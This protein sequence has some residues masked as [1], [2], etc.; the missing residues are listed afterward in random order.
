MF[1]R[2]AAKSPAP[3]LGLLAALLPACAATARTAAP[4]AARTTRVTLAARSGAAAPSAKAVRATRTH[5]V[6]KPVVIKP[7][8]SPLKGKILNPFGVQ[9]R[10]TMHSEKAPKNH[11]GVLDQDLNVTND[12]YDDVEPQITRDSTDLTVNVVFAANAAKD[13]YPP[14]AVDPT[15]NPNNLPPLGQQEPAFLAGVNDFHLY[16]R[17]GSNLQS[18]LIQIGL[19][20][21][22][23]DWGEQFEP[24]SGAGTL[25]AFSAFVAPNNDAYKPDIVKPDGTTG[26]PD[27]YGMPVR[28]ICTSTDGIPNAL[29]DNPG[30]I[31]QVL[32]PGTLKNPITY[33]DTSVDPPV[34]KYVP[35][36]VPDASPA[37]WPVNNRYILFVSLRGYDPKDPTTHY[38]SLWLWDTSKTPTDV[39]YVVKVLSVPGMSILHPK[40]SSDANGTYLLFTEADIKFDSDPTKND[41]VPDPVFGID[42]DESVLATSFTSRCYLSTFSV[43]DPPTGHAA[44][45]RLTGLTQITHYV[46][47]NNNAPRDM[48]PFMNDQ[49]Q[50][51]FSTDRVDADGDGLADGVQTDPT[52][53][54][55]DIYYF[56][57]PYDPNCSDETVPDS[58]AHRQTLGDLMVHTIPGD[59]TSPL[60]HFDDSNELHGNAA[61]TSFTQTILSVFTPDLYYQAD[62]A[63]PAQP[64]V[65]NHGWDIWETDRAGGGNVGAGP[66]ISYQGNILVGLPKVTPNQNLTEKELRN[67]SLTHRKGFPSNYVNISVNLNQNYYQFDKDTKAP[68]TEVYALVKD[69]DNRIYQERQST[70][71]PGISVPVYDEI[72]AFPVKFCKPDFEN[73]TKMWADVTD[74]PQIGALIKLKA[75]DQ[76]PH[77]TLPVAYTGKWYT[78]MEVS[79]FLIDIVVKEPAQPPAKTQTYLADNVGGF[80]TA[81]FVPSSRILVV[82]D[83]MAGQKAVDATT[84]VF[85]ASGAA[86]ESYVLN[87]PIGATAASGNPIF[88]TWNGNNQFTAVLGPRLEWQDAGTITVDPVSGR[89]VA[90]GQSYAMD[91]FTGQLLAG[92][93]AIFNAGDPM[94]VSSFDTFFGGPF[95]NMALGPH[96]YDL[97]RVQCREPI[98]VDDVKDGTG[99][100]AVYGV[101]RNYL[102]YTHTQPGY[103][104]ATALRTQRVADRCVLWFAPHAGDLNGNAGRNATEVG[105]IANVSTQAELVNYMD[106]GGRLLMSGSNVAAVLSNGDVT[107]TNALLARMK[108]AFQSD[109]DYDETHAPWQFHRTEAHQAR[110]GGL[111]GLNP[112]P[113]AMWEDH[114][115][116]NVA[117]LL[118]DEPLDLQLANAIWSR[119]SPL[120]NRDDASWTGWHNDG[121]EPVDL[122]KA[123]GAELVYY[124]TNADIGANVLPSVISTHTPTTVTDN[125]SFSK[126]AFAAFNVDAIHRWYR[127]K[128][129][130]GANFTLAQATGAMMLHNIVDFFTTGGMQGQVFITND[131]ASPKGVLVYLSDDW[132][133]EAQAL[134]SQIK[135]TALTDANGIYYIDGL[136]PSIYYV[137]AYKPGFSWQHEVREAVDTGYPGIS[138]VNITLV[139]TQPGSVTGTVYENGSSP[140][141]VLPGV[142]VTLTDI[143]AVI[144]L[145][146]VSDAT[147]QFGFLNVPTGFYTITT[148]YGQW[149]TGV[150]YTAYSNIPG[151]LVVKPNANTV[152]DI[153]LVRTAPLTLS[154]IV[155]DSS[156]NAPISGV[157]VA[158]S[159]APTADP[160][161]PVTATAATDGN[162]YYSFSDLPDGLAT[163]TT[164]D[165]QY[166]MVVSASKTEQHYYGAYS[167]AASP[168]AV[169]HFANVQFPFQLTRATPKPAQIVVSVS[170]ALTLPAHPAAGATISLIDLS[171]G[172]LATPLDNGDNPIHTTVT[173]AADDG[174]GTFNVNSGTYTI[175]VAYG[176]LKPQTKTI[177]A[178]PLVAADPATINRVN[179]EFGVLHTFTKGSVLMASLPYDYSGTTSSPISFTNVLTLTAAQL[180]NALVAYDA[181]TQAFQFYPNYPADTAHLGRGYGFV[182][183]VDGRVIDA[184]ASPSGS[185][186]IIRAEI[187]WNLIGAPWPDTVTWN[188]T[189]AHSV[190]VALRDDA[191][192][193]LMTIDDAKAK[194]YILSDLWGGSSVDANGNSV[195]GGTYQVA[196]PTMALVPYRAYW[197]KVAQPMLFY[198]PKPVAASTNA[199]VKAV[200]ELEAMQGALMPASD[201]WG[202]NITA[203][204]DKMI[205]SGL[206]LGI[207]RRATAGIDPGFDLA[208]P[209]PMG[210]GD[211]LFTAFNNGSAGTFATDIRGVADTNVWTFTVSTTL[212]T[213]PVAIS[214]TQ[215]GALPAG[216]SAVLVDTATGKRTNM[217]A[218][219]QY[220]FRTARNGGVRTFRV[221]VRRSSVI[222]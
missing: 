143:T 19:D 119:P 169:A 60:V 104:V 86:A 168:L 39:G 176:T 153:P 64:D 89:L 141:K 174:T 53:A 164:P 70:V 208:K 38:T 112:I 142:P 219:N 193:T 102:P 107:T 166:T 146:T 160:A 206:A 216:F 80:S 96:E 209:T 151:S 20:P 4:A 98:T 52:K 110:A 147:G 201:V 25:L 11:G 215:K 74:G 13:M 71:N 90:G 21:K 188:G 17:A 40:F 155:T 131:V 106:R 62:D 85:T 159:D 16:Y 18:H 109:A 51:G 204:A 37:I 213:R 46:D 202:A 87:H 61:P 35:A 184:G 28:V 178:V 171:T 177:V 33:S 123:G 72:D 173:G 152:A 77:S 182:L 120:E 220:A 175:N 12:P 59:D 125:T 84:S 49:F 189:D 217:S 179:F 94:A 111:N 103:P 6:S 105:T 138:T 163:I 135:G 207:S 5:P 1:L 30:T 78:P 69:P 45:P 50:L 183:P 93:D 203:T 130:N 122:G 31:A 222:K 116:L 57:F 172:K 83:F 99:A 198:V 115:G 140:K 67:L 128:S 91:P 114:W 126:T 97:W 23:K 162:G 48:M 95:T 54:K 121:I 139:P 100:T 68:L 134:T 76:A 132:N 214:W 66:S 194:G 41:Y 180:A 56:T 58:T 144:S 65:N 205:D 43:K 190:K 133:A 2:I 221:E 82:S 79:D 149:Q 199:S 75:V 10:L 211:Y 81:P 186:A 197:V 148:P 47:S 117:G 9:S 113:Y 200:A 108:V 24:N 36:L 212:V 44:N 158:V 210:A 181:P 32:V 167:N 137:H 195:Y 129:Y 26:A 191:T 150:Y 157:P 14:A 161:N 154:G 42:V 7:T 165:G 27:Y 118:P 73:Y 22:D 156:T 92:G 8:A 3:W 29:A 170:D 218:V 101:L 34:D 196:S 88:V 136:D 127:D 192:Q 55:F 63:F 187:G 15:K 185:T 145:H 124:Y